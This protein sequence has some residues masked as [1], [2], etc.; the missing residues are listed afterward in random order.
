MI[1]YIKGI[2]VSYD[3]ES[4]IIDNHGIG[5]HIFMNSDTLKN[6]SSYFRVWWFDTS[7]FRF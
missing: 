7:R 1:A 2:V 6:R 5:Y 3:S 4:V